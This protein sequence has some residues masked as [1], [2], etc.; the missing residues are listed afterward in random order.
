MGAHTLRLPLCLALLAGGSAAAFERTLDLRLVN[1]AIAT[2][3]SRVPMVRT[4]FH[5]PY[6]IPVGIAPIDYIEIVTPFRRI[7]QLTETRARSGGRTLGQNETIAAAGDR[8]GLLEVVVELTFHPLNTFVGVPEYGVELA[9]PTLREQIEPRQLARIPRFGPRV[10]GPVASVRDAVP[11]IPGPTTPMLGGIVIAGF[12]AEELDPK[13]VYDVVVTE[14]EK[15][16][17][18]ARLDLGRLR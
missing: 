15:S 14:G 17:A 9:G 3:D 7:V 4:R 5:Q 13:G 18:R 12:D 2:G 10:E 16:L 8:Y 11:A 1:E 6:R